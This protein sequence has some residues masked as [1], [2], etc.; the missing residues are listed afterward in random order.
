MK[1]DPHKNDPQLALG[2]SFKGSRLLEFMKYKVGKFMILLDEVSYWRQPLLYLIMFIDG[3][4]GYWLFSIVLRSGLLPP[5]VPLLFYSVKTDTLIRS[6][7]TLFLFL[8]LLALHVLAIYISSKL[9]Y[10]FRQLST[11]ILLACCFSSIIFF[12]SVYKSLSLTFP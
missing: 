9:F 3:I 4:L 5:K 10:R 1:H 7:D 2:L 12:I 11:F 6:N 8:F